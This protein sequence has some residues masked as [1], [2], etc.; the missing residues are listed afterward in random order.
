MHIKQGKEEAEEGLYIKLKSRALAYF[1]TMRQVFLGIVQKNRERNKQKT[2]R[3]IRTQD[4]GKGKIIPQMARSSI[5]IIP[6][7]S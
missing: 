5:N 2:P 3:N 1:L 7:T 6:S 4:G